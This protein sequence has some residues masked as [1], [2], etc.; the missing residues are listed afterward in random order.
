M[1]KQTK[2]VAT[3]GPASNNKEV[4][5]KLIKSGLNVVRINFSHAQY[6]ESI[7]RITM[8]DELN[9]ELDT[10]VGWLCDTK[11]PELRTHLFKDGKVFYN[12]DSVINV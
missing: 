8:L 4:L 7:A 3:I 1:Y 2:I 9:I 10:H 11:G 12:K 5:R 6:D